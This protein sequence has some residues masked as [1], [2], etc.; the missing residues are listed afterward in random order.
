MR[1]NGA[2]CTHLQRDIGCLSLHVPGLEELRFLGLWITQFIGFGRG[3]CRFQTLPRAK[4]G[5]FCAILPFTWVMESAVVFAKNP[6]NLGIL[7]CAAHHGTPNCV[8]P[9]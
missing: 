1:A 6:E 5:L 7:S 4:T 8:S 9:L 2:G 3:E